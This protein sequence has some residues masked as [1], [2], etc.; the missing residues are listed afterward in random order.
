MKKNL[1]WVALSLSCSIAFGQL[2]QIELL[3][4]TGRGSDSLL[5]CEGVVK[6]YK[7]S[8]LCMKTSLVELNK[9]WDEVLPYLNKQVQFFSENI[10]IKNSLYVKDVVGDSVVFSVTFCSTESW[11]SV[12]KF[13]SRIH[14]DPVFVTS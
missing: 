8:Y 9:Y 4:K 1:L 5:F 10:D 14:V 13:F 2:T 6:T 11:R 12:R 3:S 7:V